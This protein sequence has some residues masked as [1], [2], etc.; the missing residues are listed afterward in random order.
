MR[1]IDADALNTGVALFMAENAYLNMTALDALKMVAE[2]VQEAPNH[3]SRACA[4]WA[5]GM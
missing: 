1:L 2:W 5:V 3:R 4:E